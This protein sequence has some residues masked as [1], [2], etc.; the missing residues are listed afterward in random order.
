MP[1]KFYYYSQEKIMFYNSRIKKFNSALAFLALSFSLLAM[2]SSSS[3]FAQEKEK[4]IT[5]DEIA[6]LF[7]SY[8]KNLKQKKESKLTNQL[9]FTSKLTD[10]AKA[11]IAKLRIAQYQFCQI[12]EKKLGKDWI[13]KSEYPIPGE[14]RYTHF[15][16]NFKK[17]DLEN[18]EKTLTRIRQHCSEIVSMKNGILVVLKKENGQIKLLDTESRPAKIDD[19]YLDFLVEQIKGYKSAKKYLKKAKSPD[20]KKALLKITK[21]LSKKFNYKQ[22]IIKV[23]LSTPQ[24]A[25]EAFL[26]SLK[27]GDPTNLSFTSFSSYDTADIEFSLGFLRIFAA[28]TNFQDNCL[29]KFKSKIDIPYNREIRATKFFRNFEKIS[30]ENLSN[31]PVRIYSNNKKASARSID[32]KFIKV[33]K[34]YRRPFSR[35]GA[36]RKMIDTIN[37]YINDIVACTEV[38]TKAIAKENSN[39]DK[40]QADFLENLLK[41]SQE[42]DSKMDKLYSEKR[43]KKKKQPQPVKAIKKLGLKDAKKANS[44]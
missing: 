41:I 17:D 34:W 6:S 10:E 29:K 2:L 1:S 39:K 3:S 37:K 42:F 4:L 14:I 32:L 15:V 43:I 40:I 12:A 19:K 38:A 26:N 20:L 16:T 21:P 28:Y 11:L 24:K 33:T 36:K 25:I 22:N 5:H 23:D 9:F 7:Q 31:I 27:S 30:Q 13:E 44:K 8:T 18:E 35:P